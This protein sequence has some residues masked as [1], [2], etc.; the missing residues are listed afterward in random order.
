MHAKA[1]PV[2]AWG[3]G[4]IVVGV[5]WNAYLHQRMLE[6]LVGNVTDR[7][8]LEAANVVTTIVSGV[9]LP[10]GAALVAGAIAI[11]VIVGALRDAS[12]APLPGDELIP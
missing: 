6:W 8:T 3:I 9:V 7:L 1:K 4:L 10:L 12:P 2:L 5:I 11:H